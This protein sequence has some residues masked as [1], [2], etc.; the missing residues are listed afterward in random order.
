[1][2]REG[3]K[4]GMDR[5]DERMLSL[6]SRCPKAH[7]KI[8]GKRNERKGC[9]CSWFLDEHPQSDFNCQRRPVRSLCNNG[10]D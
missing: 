7:R 6:G 4:N 8:G 9:G 1:M 2:L 10:W 3:G 5:G